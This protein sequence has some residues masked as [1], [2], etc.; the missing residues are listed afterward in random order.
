MAFSERI[1]NLSPSLTVMI[2]S[3]AKELLAEGVDVISLGAGEPD[4]PTP[5]AIAQAGIDAILEGKTRYAAPDGLL[6]LKKAICEKLLRE[7]QLT[8]STEEIVV[9]SGAK[10]AVFNAIS[11]LINPGDEVIIP[12]PY[13][14]TY[15]ELVRYCGGIPQII[16]TGE[17][18]GFH[19]TAKALQAALSPKSKL[20]ILNSPNNPSGAVL[21]LKELEEIGRVVLENDLWVLSDEIYEHL[22]YGPA[23]HISIAQLSPEL[24]KR[25][26]L[27]NGL[28]KAYAMTGWRVGYSAAPRELSRRI[29]AMQGQTTHHPAVPSQ[30]AAEAALKSGL[31]TVH[32]MRDEFAKR[33]LFL[34]QELQKIPGLH[35]RQA[36]GAFYL[37]V[38]VRSFLGVTVNRFPIN[39]AM[40]LCQWLLEEHHLAAIPGEAFGVAGYIRLSYT[41]SMERLK[42]A[43]QR[44]HRAFSQVRKSA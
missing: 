12:A 5:R 40:E 39:S 29:A 3:R 8:Y 33:G 22:V 24:Q 32:E 15:P 9:S 13:W 1:L 30:I 31:Q 41:T 11:A 27:I 20:L 28:S 26:I 14:V 42:E 7:N 34:F 44:L 21:N 18:N 16:L 23:R 36:E 25:T 35:P 17:K 19:L 6:S 43:V 10:H 38:D 2:D 4:F 37:F